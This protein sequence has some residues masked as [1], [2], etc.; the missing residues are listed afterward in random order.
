MI[1]SQKHNCREVRLEYGQRQDKDLLVGL[2]NSMDQE[3]ITM[4]SDKS[5][6]PK[7]VM[8]HAF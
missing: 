4:K 3:N 5:R 1:S 2:F 7:P 8:P 6:G